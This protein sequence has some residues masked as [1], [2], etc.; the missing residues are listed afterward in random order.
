MAVRI[1][2]IKAHQTWPLRHRVMW[3]HKPFDYVKVPGDENNGLHFGLTKDETLVSVVSLFISR[4]GKSAQF[5]KFATDNHVQGNGFGTQLLEY[6]FDH[7]ETHG[8][9][10]RIWCNARCDKT[11]FYERFGLKRTDKVFT[12]GGID[13]VIMEKH[14]LSRK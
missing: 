4:Q 3:P 8:T 7:V 11:A 12:K 14:L 10:K 9:V 6:L 13:Y 1:A 5:R 2:A